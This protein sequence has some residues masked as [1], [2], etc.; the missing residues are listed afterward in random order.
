MEELIAKRYVKALMEVADRRAL[1]AI[2]ASLEKI[3][4]NMSSEKASVIVTSPMIATD[5]KFKLFVEPLKSKLDKNLY[6]LL[7]V[8]SENGRLNLVPQISKILNFEIK[9]ESNSFEGTVEGDKSV[10]SKNIRKLETALS[11]Y[12]GA[13]IRLKRINGESDGLKVRVDDLGLELSFSKSRIKS[14]ILSYI[15]QAL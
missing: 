15:E 2:A 4:S 5:D 11:K 10:N 12:S 7:A 8:L 6:R 14:D 13:K 9:K 3:A 1:G